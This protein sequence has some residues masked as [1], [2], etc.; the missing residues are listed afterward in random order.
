L[1]FPKVGNFREVTLGTRAQ[2]KGEYFFKPETLLTKSNANLKPE[3]LKPETLLTKRSANQKPET[4][5]PFECVTKS[6][7]HSLSLPK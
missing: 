3:N 6:G 7:H 4:L 1:N 5:K 2:R